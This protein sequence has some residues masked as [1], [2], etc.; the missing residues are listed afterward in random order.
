MSR[1][2]FIS[3]EMS[4]DERLADVAA[5]MPLAALLWPWLLLELDDWGR[6]EF[7][8]T[9]MKLSLFPACQLVSADILV[10]SVNV[11]SKHGLLA[12]YEA[13]GKTYIAVHPR[14]WIKFQTYLVGT[15]RANHTSV[16]PANPAWTD[17][18]CKETWIVMTMKGERSKVSQCQ[19]TEADVSRQEALSV[20]SPSPSPSPSKKKEENTYVVSDSPKKQKAARTRHEYSPEYEAFFAVYPARSGQKNGKHA[21]QKAFDKALREKGITPDFLTDRIRELALQY[22]DYPPDIATW[23]NNR[24]WE[25]PVAIPENDFERDLAAMRE[26]A[27][28]RDLQ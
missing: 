15:K 1:K 5:E 14:K 21:G 6:A 18:E 16:L 17:E 10:Q 26:A 28:K 11:F 8:P 25:D 7:R 19:L 24:R 27:A 22:G 4:T 2:R 13:E 20:P 23:L 3:S 12:K 9:K